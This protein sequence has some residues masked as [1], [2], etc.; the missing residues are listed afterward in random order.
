MEWIISIISILVIIFSNYLTNRIGEEHYR[1]T[2][3][4]Y[5][6]FHS[7]LPDWHDYEGLFEVVFGVILILLF[8]LLSGPNKVDFFT[9]LIIIW[10][11]RS[12]TIS[13]T[14]LPPHEK[15]NVPFNHISML[16]GG[17]HDKI[18][19][20]HTAS[21]FLATLL[22]M[23]QRTLSIPTA[24]MLNAANVF[25]ILITRGHY[26]VDIILALFITYFVNTM[27]F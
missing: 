24:V 6:L 14:I 18:F 16:S 11:I 1:K 13:V 15:C 10:L 17:C 26:T 23:K 4:I 19:S 9:K 27:K 5:D 12:I 2:T 25:F 20:G 8:F 22:L 21:L 3:A 7:L